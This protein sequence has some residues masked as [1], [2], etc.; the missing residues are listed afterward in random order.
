MVTAGAVA[1]SLVIA[2]LVILSLGGFVFFRRCGNTVAES[3]AYGLMTVMMGLSLVFQVCFL[4]NLPAAS[5]FI[6]SLVTALALTFVVRHRAEVRLALTAVRS[7]RSRHPL[8]LLVV[9]L[10]WSYLVLTAILIPPGTIH[11]EPLARLLT[12]ERQPAL[13]PAGLSAAAAAS[14]A[15]PASANTLV[16]P[17]L[18][19]RFHTD[20]G[21]GL[22]GFAAYLSIGFSVYALSRRYAWPE[23]AFTVAL[24][25]LSLP[26]MVY[27]ATSPGYDIIPTAAALFCLLAVYRTVE[28]PNLRDLYL[29]VLGLIFMISTT[30]LQLAF[31]L[32]LAALA[33]LLLFRRHGLDTW[34]HLV[35]ARPAVL[36]IV[37]LPALVFSP[38]LP[39]AYF[40]ATSAGSG[41]GRL[42]PVAAYN[43]DGLQG[44]AANAIRYLLQSIDVTAPVDGLLKWSV[45]FSIG[46]LL[47]HLYEALIA[48]VFDGRGA[49]AAFTI[50]L[51]ADEQSSWYGPFGFLL[52]LPAVAYA[53]R[54]APRR[55]KAVA[56]ALAGYFF[57][58][59][60]IPAW[61]PENVRY[62]DVFFLCGS[63]CTAFFLP[64]WRVSRRGRRVLLAT[65]IALLAYAALGNEHKPPS[66]CRTASEI[67]RGLCG[68][69]AAARRKRPR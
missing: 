53:A 58:V 38:L 27:L 66:P 57:L 16:L 49:A 51:G 67:R 47:Q 23:T 21:I 54:R 22:L 50:A 8:A 68:K 6:E 17:H 43:T 42:L 28:T 30:T 12:L 18:F 9:G 1:V 69:P 52:I 55:L 11:W 4:V 46:G 59:A 62:L 61:Q 65:G 56:V 13:F 39:W 7:L 36:P 64:P 41:T 44:A 19:L 2:E 24:M 63:V 48:P 26:R 40:P 29:L 31:P 5:L 32:V 20:A 35:A 45:G 25:A 3:G 14:A 60:L 33:L 10:L 15:G 37:A 34:R